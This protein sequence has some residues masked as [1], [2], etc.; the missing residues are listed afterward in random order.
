MDVEKGPNSD[1]GDLLKG[2]D[3]WVDLQSTSKVQVRQKDLDNS[4]KYKSGYQ[5]SYRL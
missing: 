2:I 5:K 3:Q 4:F 1:Q